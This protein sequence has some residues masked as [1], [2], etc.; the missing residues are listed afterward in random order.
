MADKLYFMIRDLY[1]MHTNYTRQQQQSSI[2]AKR[3]SQQQQ[4]PGNWPPSTTNVVSMPNQSAVRQQEWTTFTP[5]TTVQP[6]Q[7]V[8]S[9]PVT[10]NTT[11]SGEQT[12][13][14]GTDGSLRGMSLADL[15]LSTADGCSATNWILGDNSKN[16]AAAMQFLG[17]MPANNNNPYYASTIP[18]TNAAPPQQWPSYDFS[19]L[20]TDPH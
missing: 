10:Y 1:A 3:T 20:P 14:N 17:G 15:A 8:L 12:T 19:D 16:L 2:P 5:D 11:T 9:A 4:S 7:P 6:S 13:N 18:F